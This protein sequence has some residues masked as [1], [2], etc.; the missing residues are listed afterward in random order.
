MLVYN[1]YSDNKDIYVAILPD[2]EFSQ[3]VAVNNGGNL[4]YAGAVPKTDSV[5]YIDGVREVKVYKIEI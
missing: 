4:Y 2:N 5:Y 1:E 3:K